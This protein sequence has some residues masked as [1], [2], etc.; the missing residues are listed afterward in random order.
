MNAANTQ[1][2]RVEGEDAY[3]ADKS[4][5]A[6]PYTPGDARHESWEAG[7]LNAEDNESPEEKDNP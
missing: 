2:A 4:V 5:M 3:Y 6:N 7:W 1:E